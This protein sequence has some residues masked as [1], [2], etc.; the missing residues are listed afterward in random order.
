MIKSYS[1]ESSSGVR[2]NGVMDIN[3][4]QF[5]VC[6]CHVGMAKPY[7]EPSIFI[8]AEGS[9]QVHEFRRNHGNS[10]NRVRWIVYNYASLL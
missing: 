10:T 3:N 6:F 5:K 8:C 2:F 4:T 1:V 7:L 9:L